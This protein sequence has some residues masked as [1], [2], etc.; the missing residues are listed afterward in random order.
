MLDFGELLNKVWK[1]TWKHKALW[2]A[3]IWMALFIPV[4]TFV[5]GIGMVFVKTS[6]LLSY[7]RL[8]RKPTGTNVV[9]EANA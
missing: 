9:S 6:W 4:M 7:L 8:T 2:G 1:I 5:Q 3:G